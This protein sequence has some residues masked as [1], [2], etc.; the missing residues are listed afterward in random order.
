MDLAKW[1]LVMSLLLDAEL[2][3]G[4]LWSNKEGIVQHKIMIIG[5]RKG[6]QQLQTCSVSMTI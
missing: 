6:K 5:C 1:G 3:F 4:L 2:N